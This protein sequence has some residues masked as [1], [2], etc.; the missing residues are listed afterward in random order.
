MSRA[1][2]EPPAGGPAGTTIQLSLRAYA[3]LH[4]HLPGVPLGGSRVV[5]LPPGTTVGRLLD[6]SGIPRDQVKT[7]FVNGIHAELG[8]A[9]EAGDE[10]AVFPPVA[11]G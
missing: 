1:S 3:G 4:H 5:H 9:L 2:D 10:V 11:G 8:R 7:C 6:L